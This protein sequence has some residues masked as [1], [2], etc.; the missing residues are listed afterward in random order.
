M[1]KEISEHVSPDGSLTLPV[2]REGDDITIGFKGHPWHT[3]AD[4][5]AGSYETSQEVA[6]TRFVDALLGNEAV[7]AIATVAGR[8]QDVWVRDDP[9]RPDS[10]KPA[11]EVV[12]FRFWDGTLWKPPVP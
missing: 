10:Y 11:D 9:S 5:L 7:V 6:V 12:V 1:N 3:H 4:V 2:I 8:V